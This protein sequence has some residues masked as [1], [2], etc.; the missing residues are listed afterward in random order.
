MLYYCSWQAKESS[1]EDAETSRREASEN[2]DHSI[3]VAGCHPGPPFSRKCK[4]R[5]LSSPR[6]EE[7]CRRMLDRWLKGC[8]EPVTRER[9]AEV[10]QYAGFVDLADSLRLWDN[11]T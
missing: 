11:P 4:V 2:G 8:H 9:L 6:S 7:G 1:N 3:Q 10:L 5:L